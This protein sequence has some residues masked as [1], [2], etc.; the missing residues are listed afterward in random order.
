[1]SQFNKILIILII[2][3]LLPFYFIILEHQSLVM[4]QIKYLFSARTSLYFFGFISFI[5]N[6]LTFSFFSHQSLNNWSFYD[7]FFDRNFYFFLNF[8]RNFYFFLNF[9][10]YLFFFFKVVI[11]MSIAMISMTI[12]FTFA[13]ALFC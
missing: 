3:F 12:T 9:Y 8:D 1:M 6:H 10:S 4:N 7:C 13:N 11:G 2:K 5:L